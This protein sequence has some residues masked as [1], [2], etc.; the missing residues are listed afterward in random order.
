MQIKTKLILAADLYGGPF[1]LKE[2]NKLR[3]CGNNVLKTIL[4]L[5][6]RK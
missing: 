5:R 6:G 4:D 3:V 1:T 2:A